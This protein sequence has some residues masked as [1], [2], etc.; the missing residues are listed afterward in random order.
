[1]LS[2]Q[3]TAHPRL[4]DIVARHFAH[5]DLS[6]IA[7]FSKSLWPHVFAFIKA[8]QGVVLDLGCGTGMSTLLL[9]G[10]YPNYAV[11]GVDRS[12]VRLW[13]TAPSKLP[14]NALLMRIDQ[15]DLLRLLHREGLVAEKCYL[16]YP[17]PSPKA[18]H[19]K[20]RWHAHPIWPTLLQCCKALELRCNWEIYAQEFAQALA[21][22]GWQAQHSTLDAVAVDLS[23]FEKKY[24]E[25]GHGL[26]RVTGQV[27]SS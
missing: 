24:R 23:L 15:Y 9:A 21:Q 1:V 16:L 3:K 10:R 20:R 2:A 17:N 26:W 5:P 4:Q 12:E 14:E 8:H 22:S 18:A 25:S 7:D 6:P 13:K 19:I 27:N 11:I